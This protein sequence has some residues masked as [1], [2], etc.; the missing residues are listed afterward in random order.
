[1]TNDMRGGEWQSTDAIDA[2]DATAASAYG[3]TGISASSVDPADSESAEVEEIVVEID[4]TRADLT[5]TV[6]AIGQKLAPENIA[7]DAGRA[8]RG[9]T[10]GRI[11]E[12]ANNA[13]GVVGEAGDTLQE[14]GS[15]IAATIRKNPVPAAMAAIGIGWL[16]MN[17]EPARPTYRSQRPS[18]TNEPYQAS[19][20]D[21]T[22]QRVGDAVSSAQD[23]VGRTVG[24]AQDTVGRTVGTAQ[25]TVGRGFEAAQQ[26]AGQLPQQASTVVRDATGQVQRIWQENP[27][28]L[29]VLG[30]AAG[31]AAGML[32]PTTEPERRTIGP[33]RDKLIGQAEGA[34]DQTM[35][36]VDEQVSK[37][38]H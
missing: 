8:V 31:L 34:I 17:R 27:L 23:T 25:D 36:K 7:R 5:E 26:T 4:E 15:G 11:E 13:T 29:A 3:D 33:A 37:Q 28:G 30:V 19:T 6:Q 2:T 22:G 32:L 21:R 1:M 14:T 12:M 35:N 18:W 16:A 9:A 20:M 10:I 24:T 38:T